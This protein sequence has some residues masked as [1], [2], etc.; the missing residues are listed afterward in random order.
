MAFPAPRSITSLRAQGATH[1]TYNCAFERSVERC[2]YNLAELARNPELEMMAT[3]LW[4][5][6]NVQL[7]RLK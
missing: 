5:G 4:Q 3:E 1:L 6:R 2:R 7:Y